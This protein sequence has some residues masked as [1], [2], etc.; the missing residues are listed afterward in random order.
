MCAPAAPPPSSNSP[1]SDAAGSY[2][3]VDMGSVPAGMTCVSD[4]RL[5][6]ASSEAGAC[7]QGQEGEIECSADG[8]RW[9]V[10]SG[11]GWVAMGMVAAGTV[12]RGGEIV[13][14]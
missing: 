3:F 9:F 8:G 10:C 2:V 14:S 6:R 12:C 1:A 5:V 13:A 11:G 4:G 7:T